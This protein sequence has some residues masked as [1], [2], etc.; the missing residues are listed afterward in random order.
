MI[1]TPVLGNLAY[2]Q[3]KGR[4]V[5]GFASAT[6][7]GVVIVAYAAAILTETLK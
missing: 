4:K 2:Q 1:L 3:K 5:H 6:G 7:P